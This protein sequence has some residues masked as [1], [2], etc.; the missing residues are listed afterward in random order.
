MCI[1]DRFL[2]VGTQMAETQIWDTVHLKQVR[3]LA[4]HTARVGVLAWCQHVLSSGSRD[5]TIINH[6]VRVCEHRIATLRAHRQEVCGLAWCR[7]GQQLAS[8]GNDNLLHIWDAGRN[9][10]L[11]HI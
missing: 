7:D 1:R 10:S 5:S 11:I 2:A 9:L 8:G 4:G 6:D 3:N